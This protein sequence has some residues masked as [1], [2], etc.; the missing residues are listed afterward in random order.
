MKR[1]Y[2]SVGT[3]FRNEEHCIVEFIEHCLYHGIDHI[4]MINDF[5]NENFR[6][7]IQPYLDRGVVTLFENDIITT[8][9]HR[10]C[11]IYN[12]FFLPILNETEWIAIIDLDE[13]LYSPSEIDI[14]NVIKKYDDYNNI[15]VEWVNFGSNNKI[16]QPSSIVEG[17][18][19]RSKMT[20]L[21]HYSYKSIMKANDISNFGVHESYIKNVK[22][23]NLSYTNSG[24]NELLINH[25]RL[26]SRELFVNVK[27]TRG[28]VNNYYDHMGFTR[29]LDH[30]IKEDLDSNEVECTILLDQNRELIKS[31]GLNE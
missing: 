2:L 16:T 7:L 27:A 31:L 17:F 21:N 22:S 19:M 5:S 18:T 24:P 26:Q 6:P 13:F 12:K 30:F 8:Q 14:K 9:L 23:I 25:Y 1:H 10:Q 28:D 3:V 11:Q 15:K 29:D 20:N 4:Y